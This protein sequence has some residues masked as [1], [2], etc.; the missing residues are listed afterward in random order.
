MKLLLVDEDQHSIQLLAQTLSAQNYVIDVAIDGEQGWIYGSTYPYDLI[1]LNWSLPIV[2]GIELCQRFRKNDDD[3]PIILLSDRDSTKNRILAYEAGA[4]DYICKPVE[5]E[6]LAV[7]IR[8]LLRRLNYDF[9][10]IL[11]WGDLQLNPASC[12]VV[13][14]DQSLALTS[15]EYLLLELFLRHS[16][17]VLTVEDIIDHLW[18]SNEYPAIAT[19]RSHLRRLRNKLKTAG[20]PSDLI[21]TVRGQGYCLKPLPTEGEQGFEFYGGQ[22]YG[23]T[24]PDYGMEF[25]GFT[26][27]DQSIQAESLKQL[28]HAIAEI[29]HGYLSKEQQLNAIIAGQTLTIHLTKLKLS[30]LSQIAI[31]LTEAIQHY[32]TEAGPHGELMSSQFITLCQELTTCAEL[33]H[34]DG[35]PLPTTAPLWAIVT[36]DPALIAQLV[37]TAHGQGLRTKVMADPSIAQDWLKSCLLY[38]DTLPDGLILT[39]GFSENNFRFPSV[40][41]GLALI[42]QCKHLI[43][44]I[45]VIVIA[46]RDRWE[47]RLLIADHGATF[48]LAK[49]INP[50]QVIKLCQQTSHHAPGNKK[51]MVV[52]NDWDIIGALPPF[53]ESWGFK[54]TTL[55]DVRQF[56][57][58]LEAIEPDLLIL[59]LVMAHHNG[60]ELCKLLRTHPRWF[61]LPILLLTDNEDRSIVA[62]VFTSGGNDLIHKPI[63]PH[64]LAYRIVSHLNLRV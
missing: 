58:V 54:L 17:E 53:L 18:S 20:F 22:S 27:P 2:N 60:L 61:K 21:T 1:I 51:I 57:Q 31:D 4:D 30:E 23:S 50:T 35:A 43:P 6:E 40:Q 37:P 24:Q 10:P 12:E 62:D 48:Y 3:T 14:G 8:A 29:N 52:D 28:N 39:I 33:T 16:Q 47:D 63:L 41:E 13:Y 34:D 59:G 25:L 64:H 32:G 46:D 44:P 42:T 7:R 9:V 38:Q 15:K 19:V 49:P 55:D 56:W 36:Q 5:G 11:S 26:S 45:P